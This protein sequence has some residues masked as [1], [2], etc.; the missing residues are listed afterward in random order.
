MYLSLPLPSTVT[1]SI[2]VTVFNGSGDGLPMSFA[3]TVPKAG[4]CK[5]LS[6]ALA[7]ACC[8][9][10]SEALLLAEVLR[11]FSFFFASLFAH[12]RVSD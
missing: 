7:T 4:Y 2:T 12:P 5:D 1:R 3:V 11:P 6:C 8:L 9:K 10:N